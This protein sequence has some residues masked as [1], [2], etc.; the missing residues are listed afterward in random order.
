MVIRKIST[1][2]GRI[3]IRA[4]MAKRLIKKGEAIIREMALLKNEVKGK[5]KRKAYW[6]QM[7][8]D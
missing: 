3:R 7:R 4:Y 1:I 2:G 8:D 6:R 5:Y